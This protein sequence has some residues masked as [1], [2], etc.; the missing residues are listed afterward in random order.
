M[1]VGAATTV[2]DVLAGVVS[3]A[4]HNPGDL[5]VRRNHGRVS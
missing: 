2:H 5:T 3:D 1:L 4:I